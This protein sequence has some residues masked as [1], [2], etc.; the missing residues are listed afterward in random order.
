MDR[1]KLK[2]GGM[3]LVNLTGNIN[4]EFGL[5]HYCILIKT[6][7]RELFLAIPTT[8]S[9]NRVSEKHCVLTCDNS[10]ALYKHTR[11]ISNKRVVGEKKINGELC[12]LEKE[13]LDNLINGYETYIHGL[14][15][16]AVYSVGQYHKA[17]SESK[18]EMELICIEEITVRKDEYVDINTLVQ[19]HKGGKLLHDPIITKQIGSYK[20]N[21]WVKDN[22][23]QKLKKQVTIHVT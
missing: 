21:V 9:P 11:I 8:T 22:Y 3:Y 10:I 5:K 13:D 7:D 1:E 12:V 17:K 20:L 15:T 18:N 23:S 4:P 14:H 6:D 19:M 2:N 16:N